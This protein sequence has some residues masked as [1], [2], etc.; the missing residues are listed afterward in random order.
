MKNVSRRNVVRSAGWVAP[1][2]VAATAIPAYAVSSTLPPTDFIGNSRVVRTST[3]QLQ[4][5]SNPSLGYGARIFN[6]KTTDVVSAIS[7]TYWL[8]QENLTFSSY[9]VSGVSSADISA[10]SVPAPG[11]YATKTHGGYTWYPYTMTY[12]G[13]LNLVAGENLFPTYSFLT[14]ESFTNSLSGQ[15]YDYQI[16][17]TINGELRSKYGNVATQT[18]A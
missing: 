13:S 10:W 12:Q 14:N 11:S 5:R 3:Q 8:P 4:I 2:V 1:A 6:A 9:P 16:D 15:Y 18:F 7:I 17:V